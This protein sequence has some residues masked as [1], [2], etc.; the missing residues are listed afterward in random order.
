[1]SRYAPKLKG[2]S[3]L[4]KQIGFKICAKKAVHV[5]LLDIEMFATEIRS[6]TI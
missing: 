3:V 4:A 6:I 2:R 5:K 1:M